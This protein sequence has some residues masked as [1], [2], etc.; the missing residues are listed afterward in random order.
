MKKNTSAVAAGTE[1][2]NSVRVLGRFTNS[3]RNG[4]IDLLL[5]GVGNRKKFAPSLSSV[6]TQLDR[7][8]ALVLDRSGSMAYGMFDTDM[9]YITEQLYL[10]G[11]ITSDEFYEACYG[12]ESGVADDYPAIGNKNLYSR[13]Y[14]QNL[15]N[16]LQVLAANDPTA[17]KVY[18]YA[19]GMNAY[20]SPSASSS[21]A[22][23]PPFSR[24][25]LCLQAVAAFNDVLIGTDQEELIALGTFSSQGKFG[26]SVDGRFVELHRDHGRRCCNPTL[27]RYCDWSRA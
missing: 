8:V 25:D 6:C 27:W 3:S 2:A 10:D 16:Q 9:F 21:T 17:Q 18:D 23:A 14:S 19:V 26:H 12:I 4:E 5:G 11:D 22:P 24:W 20:T 7:D 1:E 13:E 15:L